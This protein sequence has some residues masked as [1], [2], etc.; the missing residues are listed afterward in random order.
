[1]AGRKAPSGAKHAR[2]VHHEA[3]AAH[4]LGWLCFATETVPTDDDILARM[5]WVDEIEAIRAEH[6]R[7]WANR[8]TG[9]GMAVAQAAYAEDGTELTISRPSGLVVRV[10]GPDGR[11]YTGPVRW[12]DKRVAII[13][14]GGPSHDITRYTSAFTGHREAVAA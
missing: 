11:D 7:Q 3:Y 13:G 12:Q 1:M 2:C 4:P 5:L 6:R 9:D 14:D 10:I 8:P